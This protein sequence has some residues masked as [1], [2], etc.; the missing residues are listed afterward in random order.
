MSSKPKLGLADLA[1]LLPAS[2]NT[3]TK[4]EVQP[5]RKS[6]L[7]APHITPAV[8]ASRKPQTAPTAQ[9]DT[10]LTGTIVFGTV[11]WYNESKGYGVAQTIV[12]GTAKEVFFHKNKA[13]TVTGTADEPRLLNTPKEQFVTGKPPRP[14]EIVMIVEEGHKGPRATAWGVRPKRNWCADA[15]NLE[16]GFQRFV[17]GTVSVRNNFGSQPTVHYNGILAEIRLTLDELQI[18]IT[19]GT[20]LEPDDTLG[21]PCLAALCLKLEGSYLDPKLER[22]AEHYSHKAIIVR[23]PNTGQEQRITIRMP[24]TPIAA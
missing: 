16:D 15:I 8:L 13:R 12:T 22:S 5:T 3:G 10:P 14:S 21:T 6:R 2:R 7:A 24:R 23:D 19:N 4:Q 20:K 9:S 17:G 18:V 11:L 1:V